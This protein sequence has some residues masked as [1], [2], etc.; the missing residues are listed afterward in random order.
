MKKTVL[1]TGGSSGIG[2]ELAKQFA[3]HDHNLILVAR[4][5]NKLKAAKELLGKNNIKIEIIAKDLSDPKAPVELYEDLKGRQIDVLINNAGFATQGSFLETN[6]KQELN[7]I[8]VN[9]SALTH[10]TKLFL[11]DMVKRNSGKIMNVASTAAFQP[12][13][14]FAAYFAT[15][16]YVLS[17][18]EAI[19]EEVSNANITITALCPGATDT[20]F[21][22]RAGTENQG[23][24]KKGETLE[25]K[26]VARIGFQGLM[27][28]K[29]IVVTGAR[30]KFMIFLLRFTPRN[31]V[32]K[33]LAYMMGRRK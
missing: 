28:G 11:P 9:I 17:L 10:L 23:F 16:A 1:I 13:P 33:V 21:A 15:K 22:R 31:T 8:Q 27:K 25:A 20:G 3:E 7:M 24:F 26:Y 19:A 2:L 30:N 4:N 14:Y 6:T 5:E 32:V 29:R 12:G 18:T